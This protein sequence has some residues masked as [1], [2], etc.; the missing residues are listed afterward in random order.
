MKTKLPWET[1]YGN[2]DIECFS[3]SDHL[4]PTKEQIRSA[5]LKFNCAIDEVLYEIASDVGLGDMAE[6]WND[7]DWYV[8]R[9]IMD[10]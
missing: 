7:D 1:P 10:L 9:E 6:S 5:R 3:L 8:F 4:N 2:Y